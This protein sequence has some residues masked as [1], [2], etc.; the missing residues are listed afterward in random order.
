MVKL[1]IDLGCRARLIDSF[2]YRKDQNLGSGTGLRLFLSLFA[3]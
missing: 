1:E 3:Y 2:I